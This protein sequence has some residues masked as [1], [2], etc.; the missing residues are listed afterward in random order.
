MWVS[1]EKKRRS[2]SM[3]KVIN[4]FRVI[5]TED[6]F[7]IEVKGD[8]EKMKRFMRGFRGYRGRHGYRGRWRGPF[9]FRMGPMMWMHGFPWWGPWDFE[10]E[11][12][13]EEEE[14]ES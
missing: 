6:G 12:E 7:R 10:E 14:E 3:D 1:V 8:K 13:G 5:E 9:G 4:E 2:K 11:D